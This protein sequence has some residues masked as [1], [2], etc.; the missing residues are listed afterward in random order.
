VLNAVV[1]LISLDVYKRYVRPHATDRQ[2]VH[3]GRVI[4]TVIAIAAMCIAP[5]LAGQDSIFGYL[6]KMNGL[7][8][9]PIFA[10]V[11]IGMFTRNVP[12]WA[13]NFSL[14]A[15]VTVIAIVYFVPGLAPTLATMHEFHF[16]GLVFAVLVLSMLVA[17]AVAPRQI[18]TAAD[19][20]NELTAAVSMETWPLAVPVGLGLVTTVVAIYAWF[21]F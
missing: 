7:Y 8:A 1:T 3:T 13:A 15:G 20:E 19:Q 10:V 12:A 6:Q 4:G 18:S 17:G 2:V 14:L 9:A 11:L 21:A 16:L 5:M